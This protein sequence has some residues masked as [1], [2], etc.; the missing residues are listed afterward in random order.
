MRIIFEERALRAMHQWLTKFYPEEACGFLLGYES[1]DT[2]TIT[3][4]WSATNISEENRK[5][6]FIVDPIDYL[7]AEKK[8]AMDGLSLLG[9][10][11]SHPEHPAIPSEHDLAAAYPFFSYTIVSLLHDEVADTRSYQLRG[12]KFEEEEVQ[13]QTQTQIQAQKSIK[14]G[15]G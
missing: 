4:T 3:E 14:K 11:H 6:R 5:R 9:I 1:G 10:Y 12:E 13:T 7:R 2:R 8:A 15:E